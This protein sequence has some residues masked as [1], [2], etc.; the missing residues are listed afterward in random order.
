MQ[1]LFMYREDNQA[2]IKMLFSSPTRSELVEDLFMDDE[3]LEMPR[4]VPGLRR[5]SPAR[6]SRMDVEDE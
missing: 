4:D 6:L 5:K 3:L 1:S 2:I